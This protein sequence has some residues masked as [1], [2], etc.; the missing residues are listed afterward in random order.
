MTVKNIVGAF[1][2]LAASAASAGQPNQITWNRGPETKIT[3]NP[4][5]SRIVWNMGKRTDWENSDDSKNSAYQNSEFTPSRK[6]LEGQINGVMEY[7]SILADASKD[8]GVEYDILAA[9]FAV[10]SGGNRYAISGKG[11]KGIAQ[12]MPST[13]KRLGVTD[14]FDPSQSIHGGASYISEYMK[15]YNGNLLLTLAA[16]NA[17]PKF[18]DS[19]CLRFGSGANL[20]QI[21]PN[22]PDETSRFIR[23]VLKAKEIFDSK[24]K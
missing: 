22:V 15:R 21:L 2:I 24:Y 10:E 17:D 16:Y 3:W 19:I 23:S 20:E 1:L 11:A 8:Y 4:G 14:P 7:S 5:R 13:Q 12:L 6:G 9:T 18:A